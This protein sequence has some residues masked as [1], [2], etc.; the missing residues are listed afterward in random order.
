MES[1]GDLSIGDSYTSGMEHV[2]EE[3]VGISNLSISKNGPTLSPQL[4]NRFMPHF[5]TSPSPLRNTFNFSGTKGDEEEDDRME[6]DEVDN[7][8]VEEYYN[9]ESVLIATGVDDKSIVEEKPI[10]EE[11]EATPE[12]RQEQ[13]N[14]ESKDQNI[15]E[16]ENV[17]SPHHSTVIKA[18]LS[19]TNLGVAAATKVEGVVPLLPAK[20]SSQ[21]ISQS[22]TESQDITEYEE[23]EDEINSPMGN[24][25]SRK[26]TNA[27]DSEIIKRE[28]RSRSK[29]QPIQVSFNTHNYFYSDK[30]GVKT[31]PLTKPNN[32]GID[33]FYDQNEAFKLPKPWSQNSHPASKASYALMSYLQLFLNAITSVVIF[34]FILSFIIALQKD[35]KST[36]EQRKYE[37]QYE[38]ESCQEQY[39]TN[40]CNQTPGLPALNEQCEMWKLCMSRNNDIFFRARSTLSAKLFGDIINSFIDPLNW[41]TLFVILCGIITWCFSSNFLLGFVRAKSYY[42]DGIKR[43]TESPPPPLQPTSPSPEASSKEN[44]HL[45]K[46]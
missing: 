16:N 22:N 14:N 21:E 46:Q 33:E 4:I 18:L 24:D 5:P 1:F 9:R 17:V 10:V 44:S 34:S 23:V 6:I 26:F 25:K 37:L 30:D 20:P 40:R 13:E 43:Y 38:S 28:L 19:P 7:T 29:Y 11:I 3:L 15:Q 45:L 41:K 42:G 12:D 32:N 36:W 39:T 27:F 31:Y 35:L 8:S 2:D